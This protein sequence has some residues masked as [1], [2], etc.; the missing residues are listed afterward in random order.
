MNRQAPPPK[1]Q[2]DDP[3]HVQLATALLVGALDTG[4]PEFGVRREQ[5]RLSIE[6]P[7]GSATELGRFID[8]AHPF[9]IDLVDPLPS[10]LV[11]TRLLQMAGIQEDNLTTG[12]IRL[13][14]N[15]REPVQEATFR[16]VPEGENHLRFEVLDRQ[17]I[18]DPAPERP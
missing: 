1:S 14:L 2:P 4:S 18:S 13:R 16:V 9:D 7:D 12:Q 11:L 5:S 8:K 10:Q 15:C 17:E 6:M 3:L